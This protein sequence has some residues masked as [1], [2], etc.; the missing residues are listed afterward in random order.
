MGEDYLRKAKLFMVS[1][2]NLKEII[3]VDS[4][5]DTERSGVDLILNEGIAKKT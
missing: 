4:Y 5:I 1:W 2:G 3:E